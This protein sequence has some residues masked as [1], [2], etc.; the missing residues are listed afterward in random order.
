MSKYITVQFLKA[1]RRI[2]DWND[3]DDDYLQHILDTAEAQLCN[4]LQRGSLDEVYKDG[5]LPTPLQHA[6]LILSA[7]LYENREAANPAKLNDNGIYW[8][9]ISHYIG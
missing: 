6:I 3:A 1:H 8:G 7:Y 4:D 9:L 5:E 2:D